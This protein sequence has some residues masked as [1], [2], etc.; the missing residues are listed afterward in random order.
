MSKIAKS[1]YDDHGNKTYCEWSDGYWEKSEYDDRCNVT[2]FENSTGF[3][4]GT[5]KAEL[6][7]EPE[8]ER[9]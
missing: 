8:F 4:S 1:E 3:K 6:E 7:H 9:E 5:P 2:Y